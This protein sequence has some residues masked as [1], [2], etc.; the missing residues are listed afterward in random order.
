MSNGKKSS[1]FQNNSPVTFIDN[2][3]LLSNETSRLFTAFPAGPTAIGSPD[4]MIYTS[5]GTF[6]ASLTVTDKYGCSSTINQNVVV[7]PAAVGTI[8]VDPNNCDSVKLTAAPGAGPFTWLV[9]SPNPVPDNPVYVKT[10]GFYKVKGISGNGCPYT[11]GPV[12]VTVKPSPDATITG[13]VNYCQGENL[14]IKNI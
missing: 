8:T 4:S 2:S 7:L 13:K 12:S 9:I 11:A 6:S 10:S 14:D 5:S 1:I 3:I